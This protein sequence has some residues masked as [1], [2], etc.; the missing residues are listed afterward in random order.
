M[1]VLASTLPLTESGNAIKDDKINNE[2][3]TDATI[4]KV[5]FDF[6][7]FFTSRRYFLC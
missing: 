1:G 2:T 6:L 4:E 7:M 5:R 3:K